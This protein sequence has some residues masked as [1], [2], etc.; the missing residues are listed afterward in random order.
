MKLLAEAIGRC[1]GFSL[2]VKLGTTLI[3]TWPPYGGLALCALVFGIMVWHG[4]KKDLFRRAAVAIGG[5][6]I[7]Q[8][9]QFLRAKD[10][11][12]A[13]KKADSNSDRN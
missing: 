7:W 1:I 3:K 2:G 8:G 12:A 10:S 5:W 13:R 9:Q 4:H 6:K 11:L